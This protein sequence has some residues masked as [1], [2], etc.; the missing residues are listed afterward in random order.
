[1]TF[2]IDKNRV[3]IFILH[4]RVNI[5]S[6]NVLCTVKVVKK[7][8]FDCLES[9]LWSSQL[10]GSVL[11]GLVGRGQVCDTRHPIMQ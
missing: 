7:L 10:E 11:L 4:S 9:F 3:G 2:Q 1:M 6:S 8:K 5:V